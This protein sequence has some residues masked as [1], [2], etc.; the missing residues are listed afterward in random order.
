M[1][2]F[3]I[4]EKASFEKTISESDV[5][6]YAGITGDMNPIHISKINAESTMF[7][8]RIAH[9]LLV[10]GFISTV[11]GMYLP[12]PG[13]IYME[14]NFKFTY[15]VKIGDTVR[16]IVEVEDIINRE[17]GIIKLLTT[18]INQDNKIVIEG[19]AVVKV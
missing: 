19:Y 15:P 12:G 9:G 5:Y 13:A 18:V 7:K 2:N 10:G 6:N 3:I 1:K 11:I 8:E 4:G 17:K 16:A 14:Q